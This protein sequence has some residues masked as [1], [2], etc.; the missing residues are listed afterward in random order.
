MLYFV[1]VIMVGH[2]TVYRNLSVTNFFFL[3]EK[4]SE[5]YLIIAFNHQRNDYDVSFVLD[6]NHY[7]LY[8]VQDGRFQN[9]R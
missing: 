9:G 7:E 3:T 5:V 1:V 2:Q 8:K 6:R 4:F